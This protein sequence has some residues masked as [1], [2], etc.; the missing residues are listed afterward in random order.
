MEGSY[1]SQVE[2][3]PHFMVSKGVFREVYQGAH[4]W[5]FYENVLLSRA[6]IVKSLVLE[7]VEGAYS[8][9]LRNLDFLEANRECRCSI[10]ARLLKNGMQFTLPIPLILSQDAT[11]AFRLET[12]VDI[13]TPIKLH[14]I[15]VSTRDV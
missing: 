5:K 4:T 15:G 6:F 8:A 2:V 3:I 13:V 1:G 11:W 9:H 10:P 12:N 14:L 7:G